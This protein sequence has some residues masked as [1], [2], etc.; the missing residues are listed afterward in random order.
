MHPVLCIQGRGPLILHLR[1]KDE[2]TRRQL[3]AAILCAREFLSDLVAAQKA[4]EV[5]GWNEHLFSY[6][7][8]REGIELYKR[9]R[10]DVFKAV[11]VD[12]RLDEKFRQIRYPQMGQ[13]VQA[14]RRKLD[15][16]R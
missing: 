6:A 2:Q 7:T 9:H 8:S 12:D 10:I 13:Q 1:S 4:R 5:Y 3:R 11:L 14:K 16:G 15:R